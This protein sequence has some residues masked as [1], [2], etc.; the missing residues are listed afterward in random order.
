MLYFVKE[1]AFKVIII[2]YIDLFTHILIFVS[3]T[4]GNEVIEGVDGYDVGGD[5]EDNCIDNVSDNVDS[6]EHCRF[7]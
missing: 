4:E 2:F 5:V 6:D 1:F 7:F 3:V